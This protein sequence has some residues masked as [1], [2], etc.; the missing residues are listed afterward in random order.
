MLLENIR[1]PFYVFLL[2]A[3]GFFLPLSVWLLSAL[4]ISLAAFWL[5]TG[6]PVN[7]VSDF[8]RKRSV[9]VFLLFYLVYLAG[10]IT[11]SDLQAGLNELKNKLPVIAFPLIIGFSESLDKRE[12]KIIISSFIAGVIISSL[13]GIILNMNAADGEIANTRQLSVFI[14]HIRL[15]IMSVLS[16]YVS[17]HYFI[18][19]DKRVGPD[20]LFLISGIWMTIFLFILL[21][22]T[23]IFIFFI[24]LTG[25]TIWLVFKPGR[26]LIKYS[27]AGVLVLLI[28]SALLIVVTS[29]RSFYT[30]GNAYT[31]PLEHYTAAGKPYWHDTIN[32]DTENGNPVWIYINEDEL[33]YGWNSKSS[34]PYD[35]LDNTGQKLKYTLI[36]YLTSRGLRKDGEGISDLTPE[37]ISNIE[38]GIA[39]FIY[40]GDQ[41]I[42]ARIYDI[43][44]QVDH[45]LRG[46]N[47][48][49]HSVT[50]RIEFMKTG[51]HIFKRHPLFGIGTGDLANEIKSQYDLDRSILDEPYRLE[52]HNQ[53]V[54][55]L[56]LFG[57][58]GFSII[59]FSLLY[60][61]TRMLRYLDYPAIIFF[62]IIM[63]SMLGED[64]LETQTGISFFAYFYSL[65]I[66]GRDEKNI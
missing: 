66:F 4:T 19:S 25:T 38:N 60:P 42:K 49:G 34:L 36:R 28:F 15:A 47:P 18:I 35:S 13:S 5:L 37:D 30:P 56:A 20:L 8:R 6:G 9:I 29:V 51:L 16:I 64:T 54:T 48:S 41:H 33:R 46:G 24:I 63:I 23:G 57:L 32:R 10:M 45:Y 39:N 21:S 40:S 7:L 2:S 53:F 65:F 50:Q 62:V 27:F 14:S 26:L 59:I 12:L 55:F 3:T 61:F 31:L 22:A 52:A 17:F 1:R 43:I 44:W 11:T 58:T